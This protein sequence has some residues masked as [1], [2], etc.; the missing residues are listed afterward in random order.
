MKKKLLL[1]A[2]IVSLMAVLMASQSMAQGEIQRLP[3]MLR[4]SDI[5]SEDI[6]VGPGYRVKDSVL[7]DGF[8]NTYEIDT[9]Y[10]HLKVESTALLMTR[11]HEIKTLQR[12]EELK[13]SKLYK[14]AFIES[15]KGP[16]KT[17][18]GLVTKPLKTV[19]GTVTGVGRWFSDVGRAAVSKDPYQEGVLKT[20]V[21]HAPVKRKFAYEFGV[22]PYSSFEPLQKSLNEI[23]WTATGGAFTI[24]AAFGAIKDRP[25]KAVRGAGTAAGMKMLVRDKS[26]SEL[27]KINK[28]EI[29]GYGY[30]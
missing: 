22:D 6:L 29:K 2:L 26:P 14:D 17:A 28:E 4:A 12:M 13:K 10:G 18:K 9:V 27:E 11:L 1:V 3:I 24:K 7:N 19:S 5:L 16:L 21:G 23:A 15:A 20:A 30:L 8:I 25:G